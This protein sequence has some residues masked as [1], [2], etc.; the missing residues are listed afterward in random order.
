MSGEDGPRSVTAPP[1]D[2]T[3]TWYGRVAKPAAR[4]DASMHQYEHGA[5]YGEPD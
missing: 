5:K 4:I 3:S 2:G 1:K